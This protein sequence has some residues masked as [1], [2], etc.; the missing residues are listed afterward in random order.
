MLVVMAP[1][2]MAI[3]FAMIARWLDQEEDE[4]PEQRSIELCV[5]SCSAMWLVKDGVLRV[6]AEQTSVECYRIVV[7]CT[8]VPSE[9]IPGEVDGFP[10]RIRVSTD[11]TA[12]QRAARAFAQQAAERGYVLRPV[13]NQEGQI[14]VLSS[15]P[16][17]RST[18]VFV[19]GRAV[20]PELDQFAKE[21]ASQEGVSVE[22]SVAEGMR[23]WGEYPARIVKFKATNP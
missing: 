17:S 13:R 22:Q 9:Q 6:Y 2:A 5:G 21:A 7:D 11:E 8:S 3:G 19:E 20:S 1:W 23:P 12:D 4:R 10:V 18:T 16:S 15:D 14:C